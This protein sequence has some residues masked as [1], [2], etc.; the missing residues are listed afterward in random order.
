MAPKIYSLHHRLR[1][2]SDHLVEEE[3]RVYHELGI[4]IP[5]RWH[6]I[7]QI[8]DEYD[9]NLTISNLAE[10]QDKTHPDVVYTV[11]QMFKEGLIEEKTDKSD[12]RKRIIAPTQKA[13]KLIE[14]LKPSWKASLDA[15][16]QWVKE[17]APDLWLNF[18]SLHHSLEKRSFFSRIK[19]ERKRSDLKNVQLVPY[20][21]V[22][23]AQLQLQNF[24]S[25]FKN[26]YFDVKELDGQIQDMQRLVFKNEAETFFSLWSGQIIGCISMLRRSF[27]FSE[28]VLLWVDESFRRRYI[29]TKL[30]EKA[31]SHAREIGTSTVFI[32]SHPKLVAANALFQN[33]AF[34]T[35]EK[36]PA[37]TREYESMTMVLIHELN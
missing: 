37:S 29:A 16:N 12:K 34:K 17:S 7:L 36:I 27:K 6:A 19:N 32:Q 24:W 26:K 1:H 31:L 4:D 3:M 9:Q 13:L 11:N 8:F 23:D 20:H 5:Y 30:L 21:E 28:I 22:K 18:E 35:S 14:S 25:Q 15:T 33:L 10:I 2:L